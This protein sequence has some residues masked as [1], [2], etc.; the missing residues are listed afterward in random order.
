M[1]QIRGKDTKPEILLRKTLWGHGLRYRVHYKL[2]GRPDIVLVAQKVAVFVD[3]CFWHGCPEHAVRPKINRQFWDKKLQ[4]NIQRDKRNR[5]ALEKLG[6]KVLRFWEHEVERSVDKA[7][8]VILKAVQR[9][10]R[11]A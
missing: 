3:G 9:R 6:W 5:V 11:N 7:A 1:S 8:S 2:P 4:G 10:S